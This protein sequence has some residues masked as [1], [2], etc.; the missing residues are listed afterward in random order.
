M[1][2]MIRYPGP[3]A[4][5]YLLN[6][7]VINVLIFFC[8]M[9]YDGVDNAGRFFNFVLSWMLGFDKPFLLVISILLLRS[10]FTLDIF[11]F[12]ILFKENVQKIKTTFENINFVIPIPANEIVYMT[13]YS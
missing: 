12:Y 7:N 5:H 10:V 9:N 1:F 2:I 11:N 4:I 6:F 13:Y 8:M 3:S